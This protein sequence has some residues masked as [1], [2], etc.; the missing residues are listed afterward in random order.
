MAPR[1][2]GQDVP[3]PDWVVNVDGVLEPEAPP[4]RP[5]GDPA[6]RTARAVESIRAWAMFWSV[7]NLAAIVIALTRQLRIPMMRAA[8]FRTGPKYSSLRSSASPVGRPMRAR[9]WSGGGHC[10][11]ANARCLGG[12]EGF[13]GVGPFE[14]GGGAVVAGDVAHELGDEVVAAVE[15]ELPAVMMGAGPDGVFRIAR[16]RTLR[17]RIETGATL[18][19]VIAEPGG[20]L[21]IG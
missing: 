20:S 16:L 1:G 21:P 6:E 7:L 14:W 11:P 5:L 9:S 19:K 3:L 18:R 4:A 8:R 17:V 2:H 13:A 10:S 12:L 15:A